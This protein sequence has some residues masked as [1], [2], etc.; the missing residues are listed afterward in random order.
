MILH[1][2][3]KTFIARYSFNLQSFYSRE[4]VKVFFYT[5]FN[6]NSKRLG[7]DLIPKYF[8]NTR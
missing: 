4:F 1:M 3:L 7:V 8:D 5:E 6:A 2:D